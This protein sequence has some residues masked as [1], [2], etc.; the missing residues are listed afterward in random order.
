MGGG[1]FLGEGG[2]F[3]AHFFDESLPFFTFGA[4]VTNGLLND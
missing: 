4:A 2:V 1:S 3:F